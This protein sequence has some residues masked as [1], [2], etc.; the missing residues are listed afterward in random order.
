M[1]EG[2]SL[3]TALRTV[4]AG[5]RRH[6]EL[7]V[8]DSGAGIPAHLL[9][10]IFEP[11]FTTRSAGTG[12]GLSIVKRIVESHTGTLEV[13]SVVGRGTT[14]TLRLPLAS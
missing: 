4:D 9:E 12:L 2:G 10:R 1:P 3:V 11:F 6:V 7:T 5:A 13:A 8:C 14:V